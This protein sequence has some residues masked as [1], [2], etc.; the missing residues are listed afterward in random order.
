MPPIIVTVGLRV[1]T[2]IDV[3][4][5]EVV[6]SVCRADER[7]DGGVAASAGSL[8]VQVGSDCLSKPVDASNGPSP[9]AF[10]IQADQ[11]EVS[12]G[13]RVDPE[14]QVEVSWIAAA[15]DRTYKTCT[16]VDGVRWCIENA[17]VLVPN[18][19][20]LCDKIKAPW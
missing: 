5:D 7:C 9:L 14:E 8:A 1:G 12:G 16:V 18:G 10:P 20:W 15:G 19:K 17:C 3:A 13:R 6:M 2:S 11:V 4:G